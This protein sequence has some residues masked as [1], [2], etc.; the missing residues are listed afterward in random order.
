MLKVSYDAYFMTVDVNNFL[1]PC[2]EE[3]IAEEKFHPYFQWDIAHISQKFI[4][5][6]I[7]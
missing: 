3:V 6:S 1:E 5:V 4:V 2:F 7:N